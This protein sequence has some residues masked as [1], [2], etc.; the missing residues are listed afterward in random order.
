MSKVWCSALECSNNKKGKCIIDTI[1]L[2]SADGVS[3]N[4]LECKEYKFVDK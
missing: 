1:H 2:P 3:Y 4:L